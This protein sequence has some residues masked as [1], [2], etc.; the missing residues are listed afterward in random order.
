MAGIAQKK[1][2]LE[3]LKHELDIDCHKIT[4]QELFQRFRTHP[5]NVILR[6]LHLR[7]S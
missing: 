5:E 4:K 3:D 2:N 6:K 7:K 1:E